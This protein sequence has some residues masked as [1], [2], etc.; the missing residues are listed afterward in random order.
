M[1]KHE[2]AMVLND[3]LDL[4]YLHG[5]TLE[6]IKNESLEESKHSHKKDSLVNLY[7]SLYKKYHI[8]FEEPEQERKNILIEIGTK[9]IR[10]EI[11]KRISEA[12]RTLAPLIKNR[13]GLIKDLKKLMQGI[14]E[15]ILTT[16]NF[17]VGLNHIEY[18]GFDIDE[19]EKIIDTVLDTSTDLIDILSVDY[20]LNRHEFKKKD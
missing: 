17:P 4:M 1:K 5:I 13:D 8:D 2:R 11:K 16:C 10:E 12:K 18:F 6:E 15:Y 14:D 19:Y 7:D 9:Q 20:V 3:I